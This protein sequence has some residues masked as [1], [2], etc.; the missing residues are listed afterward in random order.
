MSRG[1]YVPR[2]ACLSCTIVTR[3]V[4]IFWV[5]DLDGTLALDLY[6]RLEDLLER[7]GLNKSVKKILY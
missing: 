2:L 7:F 1:E 5:D 3:D 6:G 4:D